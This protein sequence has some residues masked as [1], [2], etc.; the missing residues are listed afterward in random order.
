MNRPF[1]QVTFRLITPT[2][3]MLFLSVGIA[4]EPGLEVLRTS[5]VRNVKHAG[6]PS[7]FALKQPLSLAKTLGRTE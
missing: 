3:Q 7:G 6:I 1:V 5:M 2:R 4:T